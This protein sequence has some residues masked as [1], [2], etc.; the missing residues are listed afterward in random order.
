MQNIH[1][2]RKRFKI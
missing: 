2:N 1:L